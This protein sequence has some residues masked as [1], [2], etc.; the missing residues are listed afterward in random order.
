MVTAEARSILR[1]RRLPTDSFLEDAVQDGFEG[2]GE[3]EKRFKPDKG[4]PLG[5][6][7]RPFVRGAIIDGLNGARRSNVLAVLLKGADH[8]AADFLAANKLPDDAFASPEAALAAARKSVDGYLVS[9]DLGYLGAIRDLDPEAALSARREHA[10]ALQVM[11][12]EFARLP[13]RDQRVLTLREVEELS[14]DEV[15]RRMG[16]SKSTVERWRAQAIDRLGAAIRARGL[17]AM[18]ALPELEGAS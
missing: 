11:Q 3:A 5:A 16:A 12:E 4:V 9:L 14:W 13:E 1:Q 18:P 2:L 7:A 17:A 15:A 8:R 10:F 6:Y